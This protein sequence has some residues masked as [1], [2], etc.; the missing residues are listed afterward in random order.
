[1]HTD[2][3]QASVQLF[4][5]LVPHTVTQVPR[6]TFCGGVDEGVDGAGR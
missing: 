3:W 2:F 5:W 1:M 6:V 4:S